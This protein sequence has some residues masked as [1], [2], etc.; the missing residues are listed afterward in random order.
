MWGEISLP[1]VRLGI[2]Q[3]EIDRL[4]NEECGEEDM[5]RI[6]NALDECENL[7]TETRNAVE[8]NTNVLNETRKVLGENT[9]VLN[10]TRNAVEENTNVLNETRKDLGENTNALNETRNT[11]EENRN[12]LNQVVENGYCKRF[13]LGLTRQL[14]K[15]VRLSFLT[16]LVW[17]SLSL[18]LSYVKDLLST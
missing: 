4:E 18:L 6:R 9:N 2:D 16:L 17:V 8:E 5:K 7:L 10:E 1:L 12:V 15:I 13:L 14:L 3:K 11:A